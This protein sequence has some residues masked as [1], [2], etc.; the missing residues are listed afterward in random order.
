MIPAMTSRRLADNACSIK[1]MVFRHA[2][3]D[4]IGSAV[5]NANDTIYVEKSLPEDRFEEV[6][7]G[8]LQGLLS[9]RGVPTRI[10]NW[11]ARRGIRA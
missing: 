7:L 8:S 10:T 5:V 3:E 4:L 9:E 1:G 2:V 6:F 11:F